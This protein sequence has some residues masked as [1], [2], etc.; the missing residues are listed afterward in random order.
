MAQLPDKD[1]EDYDKAAYADVERGA[2]GEMAVLRKLKINFNELTQILPVNDTQEDIEARN[3]LFTTFDTEKTGLLTKESILEGYKNLGKRGAVITAVPH[4]LE[5]AIKITKEH[6]RSKNK[7]S[8][9]NN[10]DPVEF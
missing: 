4:A 5:Q 8:R 1:E 6:L 2:S 3:Q 9:Y 7:N 10:I